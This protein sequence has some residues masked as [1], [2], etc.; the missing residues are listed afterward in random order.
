MTAIIAVSLE[1]LN[2]K[3]KFHPNNFYISSLKKEINSLLRKFSDEQINDSWTNIKATVK[4]VVEHEIRLL[5][6]ANETT[7]STM[8]AKQD[9]ETRSPQTIYK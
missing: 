4:S 7:G 8:D 9:H 3:I 5:I 2:N 6:R 1:G